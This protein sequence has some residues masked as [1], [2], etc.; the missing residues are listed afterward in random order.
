M[1]VTVSETNLK[2]K[3]NEYDVPDKVNKGNK[4]DKV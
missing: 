4:D 1:T 3:S 2:Y